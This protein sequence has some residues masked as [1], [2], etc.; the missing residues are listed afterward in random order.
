LLGNHDFTE[1]DNYS[2]CHSLGG[3]CEPLFYAYEMFNQEQYKAMAIMIGKYGSRKYGSHVSNWPCGIYTGQTPGLML[4]LAGIGHF[5]LLL[6]DPNSTPSIIMLGKL[7][8]AFR[9]W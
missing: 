5:Y 1:Y 2:F 4:G 8:L 6:H 7:V 9:C 3:N